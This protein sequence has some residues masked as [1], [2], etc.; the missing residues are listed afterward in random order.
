ML[1]RS[2]SGVPGDAGRRPVYSHTVAVFFSAILGGGLFGAA[3]AWA[4]GPV[5]VG[6]EEQIS[7]GNPLIDCTADN[8][9]VQEQDGSVVFPSA[10]VEPSIDV[11][12]TDSDNLIAVWQQDRWSD[13]GSRALFSAYS[14]DGGTTWS[15]VVL[16]GLTVC[17]GTGMF[18]RASDPWVTFA[19]D[20]AAYAIGLPFDSDPA[21]FGGNHA[22]TVNKSIDG[23]KS[24]SPPVK[25][26]AE[27]DPDVFNDKES[28][29]ADST[30]ANRVYATW[31][32]LE[33]FT[34]SAEQAAALAASVRF[35]HDKIL[36]AGQKLRQM[37]TAALAAAA[38]PPSFKGPT[39]FTRTKN[40]GATWELPRIVYDPGADNQTI[41][42]IVL[43]Q[44]SGAV[45]LV[46]TE[47]LNLPNGTAQANIALKRSTDS[48][49]SFLPTN[50]VIR[51]QR[52][53]TN[54]V[55][56][57]D[58]TE[59]PDDHLPVRDAGILFDPAVDPHNGNLYLV[60]QDNR[61]GNHAVDQI[62][63]SVSKNNGKTWSNPIEINKT[64][65][66]PANRLRE[67]A[68]VPTIAVNSAGMLAVTYYDF[69]N[70]DGTGELADQFALFCDSAAHNCTVARNW[71]D[72][73][74][75]TTTSFDIR[76]AAATGAGFFLGDYE[77]LASASADVQPAYAKTDGAGES[78]IYTRKLSIPAAVASAA[79]Q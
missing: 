24:W 37:R 63:F 53:H 28:I 26:I 40:A 47:I 12:P 76:D 50:G 56:G 1:A 14:N 57:L 7:A 30:S 73:K 46:F 13:G 21:V 15:P 74:R 59:T 20:G 48:G 35:E 34:A 69:R 18:E 10:E 60:W 36:V 23:G 25:L 3:A 71:G 66:V 62:A 65:R 61:F 42:N 33:N 68:F 32:R 31:D 54:A 22:V 72:E 64:P 16:P 5:T 11:N 44:P 2:A 51:A 77:G 6:P 67:A 9:S 52:I 39:M 27:N 8:V 41:N 45:V 38:A 75:L 79:Q 29:T 19:P 70:D 55:L 43:V 4:G 78:S 58:T 49:F 17:D